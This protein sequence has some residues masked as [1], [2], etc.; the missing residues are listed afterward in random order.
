[1]APKSNVPAKSRASEPGSGVAT[2]GGGGL[3]FG[4]RGV[5]PGGRMGGKPTGGTLEATRPLV[6][7]PGKPGKFTGYG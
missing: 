5:R 6:G 7:R 3:V 2:D 4:P 1:M